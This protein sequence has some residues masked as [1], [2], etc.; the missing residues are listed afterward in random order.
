MKHF[1]E[2]KPSGTSFED[3][4]HPSALC[5]ALGR[6]ALGFAALER[7]VD[8]TIRALAQNAKHDPIT[9]FQDC[10]FARKLDLLEALITTAG[11]RRRF[12]VGDFDAAEVLA[13]LIQLL[14]RADELYRETIDPMLL[15]LHLW[16]EFPKE[17]PAEIMDVADY[18]MGVGMQ[19]EEFFLAE[20]P[21]M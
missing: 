4:D 11:H 13:E 3:R 2:F 20:D 19:L 14:K 10:S 6:V 16:N 18:L 15:S 5:S 21:V 7:R 12:N 8:A 17:L 1:E 9:S